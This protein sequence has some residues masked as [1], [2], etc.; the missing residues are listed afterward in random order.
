[1]NSDL[2]AGLNRYEIDMAEFF[3]DL[4]DANMLL[5]DF[6]S[7][8]AE[9]NA[10]EL[11][12]SP[13]TLALA[14]TRLVR[15]R[16][17]VGG[18]VF[19]GSAIAGVTSGGFGG[20]PADV[21]NHNDSS[22]GELFLDTRVSYYRDFLTTATGGRAVFVVPEPAATGLLA[23]SVLFATVRSARRRFIK[24][25]CTHAARNRGRQEDER[26]SQK[27]VTVALRG[28]AFLVTLLCCTASTQGETLEWI[29]QL[30]TSESDY[31]YGVS[32]DGLGNLYIAGTTQGSLA[33]VN[34]G[35][36]DAFLSKY[37]ASGTLQ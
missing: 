5:Y 18:P 26:C 27:N 28:A 15:R 11:R 20:P 32:A 3:F 2:I 9:N 17:T 12:A 37:T 14:T 25:R 7:G 24:N 22:W 21:T 36:S 4:L 6:D 35:G 16:A 30:G 31:A 29:Q 1:M 23:V 19:L 10:L 34:A 8:L 33:G 13:P